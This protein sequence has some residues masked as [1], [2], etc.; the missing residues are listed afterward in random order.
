MITRREL[1]TG[2]PAVFLACALMPGSRLARAASTAAGALERKFAEIEATTGGRLGVAVIDTGSGLQ[3][4]HR[5][6][7]R[8]PL[9]ST[10]K[11]LA[12]AA[13]LARVDAGQENGAP[14]VIAAYLTG[15]KVNRDQQNAAL[16]DVGQ[17]VAA[18]IG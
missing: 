5:G 9:C 18:V 12:A 7:E 3:A 6:D 4:A 17:A 15:A 2:V 1:A 14:I 8:F 11:L 13:I 16:A 10:F